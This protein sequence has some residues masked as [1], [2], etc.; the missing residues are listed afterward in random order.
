MKKNIKDTEYYRVLFNDYFRLVHTYAGQNQNEVNWEDFIRD[1]DNFVKK[2]RCRYCDEIC[3]AFCDEKS[4]NREG[5][6]IPEE[7]L[8]NYV[9]IFIK[10]QYITEKERSLLVKECNTL[11]KKYPTEF[12]K[13][14]GQALIDEKT[15]ELEND[16]RS[17]AAFEPDFNMAV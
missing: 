7:F 4:R 12:C 11:Y 14:L 15:R 13:Q 9:E 17:G 6:D 10:Y 5:S 8:I 1:E 2:Y 16:I 3:L